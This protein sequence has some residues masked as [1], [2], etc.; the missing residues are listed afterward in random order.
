MSRRRRILLSAGLLAAAVS[1]VLG[2][3]SMLPTRPGVTKANFDRIEEGMTTEE[4]KAILGENYEFMGPDLANSLAAFG[5]V[6]DTYQAL[7]AFRSGRVTDKMWQQNRETFADKL[8]RWLHL[9]K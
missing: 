7:I 9:P 4:V 1:L 8:R 2:V 3:L 5:F 6:A